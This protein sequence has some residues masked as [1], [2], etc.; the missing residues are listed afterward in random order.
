MKLKTTSR[1]IIFTIFTLISTIQ[2]FSQSDSCDPSY[3]DVCISPYP[4]DLNCNDISNK[5]FRVLYPDPHKFERE[6][7]GIDCE[8]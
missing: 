1:I 5:N 6:E 2:V 3:P 8:T 4:P 7:Y